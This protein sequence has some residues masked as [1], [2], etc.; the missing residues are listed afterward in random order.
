MYL[1]FTMDIEGSAQDMR[2]SKTT[3]ERRIEMLFL[4][5]QRRNI[6]LGELAE[7]FSVHRN[8]AYKDII[9]LSLY[10]PIYTKNGIGGGVFL[11]DGYHNELF[12]YLTAD[13]EKVLSG[14]MKSLDAAQ[15]A[16]VENIINK[17]S[18]PKILK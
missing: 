4:L 3:F 12:V 16:I 15:K 11:M 10:A 9:F 7:I 17:F 6:T 18:M 2:D 1:S 14:L 5:I 13:E 8:T